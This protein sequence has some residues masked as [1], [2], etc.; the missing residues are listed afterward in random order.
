MGVNRQTQL[1]GSLS[2]T[3]DQATILIRRAPGG[4][5]WNQAFSLWLFLSLFLYQLVITRLLP[6]TEKGFYELIL[7]PANVGVYLAALG[8][9]SAG[10]VYIPRMLSEGGPGKALAVA[11]RLIGIRL[12]AVLVIA[13]GVLWGVPAL[14]RLL[15]VLALPGAGA[16]AQSLSDPMLLA[17]HAALIGYMAGMGLANLLAALLTALLRTR[18]I[19]IAGSLTQV[20]TIAL[21]Y[22]FVGPLHGG[23]DSALTALSLPNILL[24]L[25]YVAALLYALEMRPVE[26]G[27]KVTGPMLRLGLAAWVADLSSEPL[28]KLLAVAQLSLVV[29]PAQIAFFGIAFEMGHAAAYLFVAGL[30]G[31]GLAVMSAAYA[32]RQREHLAVAW[33]TITKLQVLLAVPLLAF[34]IPYASPITRLLYGQNYASAGPLLALF[35]ALNTLARLCGGGAHEAALY[36]LGRQRWVVVIRSASLGIL[37]T[38]DALLIPRF[39]VA[40]ALVAVGL[41]QLAAEVAELALAR[42]WV[43]RPFP[44]SFVLRVAL[45]LAPAL[46]LALLWRPTSL[47]G[48][49][50]AGLIYSL[51]FLVAL[52]LARPLDTED[53]ALLQH[54]PGPL[55]RI[56]STL[57]AA[58]H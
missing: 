21:A 37:I 57:F 11:L 45:A 6:V 29:S 34:C 41:A 19:F 51:I 56:L 9:E 20:L 30:G 35:L 7:T 14:A 16:L 25:V 52:R 10:A 46:A 40:G 1:P 5:L 3:N 17:H 54:V 12:A 42:L 26:I 53:A 33:R 50:L 58:P 32:Q 27:R 39:G 13:I 8:L 23:A 15:A 44:L 55:P 18:I 28:I 38:A 22:L 49:L 43:A 24:A 48:L 4:Y 2:E 47:A 31:I 36:V